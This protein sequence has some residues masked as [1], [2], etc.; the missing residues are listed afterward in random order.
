MGEQLK[1]GIV[2]CG[3]I[4]G[5]SAFFAR[6]NRRIRITACCDL[7]PKRA[8]RFAR[9]FGIPQVFSDFEV[10]LAQAELDAESIVA[11]IAARYQ[12]ARICTT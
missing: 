7:N 8:R 12:P 4:A 11:M 9:R 1:L 3:D 6:L 2:G 10:M 5:Y